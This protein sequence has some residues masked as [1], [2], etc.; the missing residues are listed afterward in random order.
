MD[1]QHFLTGAQFRNDIGDTVIQSIA[2]TGAKRGLRLVLATQLI[3][4]LDKRILDS[5]SCLIVARSTNPNGIFLI[6]Q[7]M[8]LS[9]DQALSMSCL[10][11]REVVV[12][13]DGHPSPFKVRVHDFSFPPR[14]DEPAL[15]KNAQDSLNHVTWTEDSD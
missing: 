6:Q 3:S 1:E 5:L 8:G 7:L 13:Y 11:R 9:P 4:E 15:E 14:L 2:S 12:S 10:E